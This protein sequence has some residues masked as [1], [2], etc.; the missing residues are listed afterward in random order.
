MEKDSGGFR[1]SRYSRTKRRAR[2]NPSPMPTIP[3]KK[4]IMGPILAPAQPPSVPKIEAPNMGKNLLFT[5]VYL[6]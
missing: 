4:P 1:Y 2:Y 6:E 3:K 5:V